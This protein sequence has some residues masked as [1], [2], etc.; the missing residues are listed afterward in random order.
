MRKEHSLFYFTKKICTI[1]R[2]SL[3]LLNQK[4]NQMAQSKKMFHEMR[5]QNQDH[6]D[7]EYRYEMWMGQLNNKSKINNVKSAKEELDDL[8]ETFGRIFGNI[9]KIQ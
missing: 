2:Q 3:Y 8:F 5:E 4:S 1:N 9:N 7:D 6:I